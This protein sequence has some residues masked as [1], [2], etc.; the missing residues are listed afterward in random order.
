MAPLF[1]G[2]H[3]SKFQDLYCCGSR[4]HS[5]FNNW[6]ISLFRVV[7]KPILELRDPE[8]LSKTPV[9][10]IKMLYAGAFFIAGLFYFP[11]IVR[12]LGIKGFAPVGQVAN[13]LGRVFFGFGGPFKFRDFGFL[14]RKLDVIRIAWVRNY[15]LY[16]VSDEDDTFMIRAITMRRN[17]KAEFDEIIKL[18]EEVTKVRDAVIC[19]EAIWKGFKEEVEENFEVWTQGLGIEECD[20]DLSPTDHM[21][22]TVQ[23]PD[24]CFRSMSKYQMWQQL[25]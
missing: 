8:I 3:K 21:K 4:Y 15:R 20:F 5:V 18:A 22:W 14:I 9:E 1:P 16:Q 7:Y 25:F 24:S 17:E 11:H 2:F 10:R 6:N 23:R 13:M 19:D 12:V